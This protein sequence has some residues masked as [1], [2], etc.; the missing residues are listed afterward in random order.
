M[1]YLEWDLG[2]YDLLESKKKGERYRGDREVNGY[3]LEVIL[4][5]TERCIK[6]LKKVLSFV[7]FWVEVRVCYRGFMVIN[8]YSYY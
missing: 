1:C 5:F 2:K 7:V 3:F 6:R 4:G 8:C